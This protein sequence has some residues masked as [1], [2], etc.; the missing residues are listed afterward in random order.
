MEKPAYNALS[1]DCPARQLLD[2]IADKWVT[3]ILFMLSQKTQRYSELLH[4]IEGISKK[5]L[6]QVLRNLERDGL[7][8]RTV[9]PIVPPHVEYNLTELGETLIPV[10]GALKTW[11]ETHMDE[12][13][14]SRELY[15]PS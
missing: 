11:S 2:M 4:G 12:V 3:L 15:T 7:L 8:K 10:L 6:T 1:A 9:Y 13:I 14:V 5:M